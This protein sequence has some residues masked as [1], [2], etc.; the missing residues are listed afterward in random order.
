MRGD[1]R[2]CNVVMTLAKRRQ[3]KQW[4]FERRVLH[5]LSLP[6]LKSEIESNFRSVVPVHF[7]M[8]PF[9]LDPCMDMMIDVYLIGAS[10]SKFRYMGECEKQIFLR[11]EDEI[12]HSKH[13]LFSV[14]QGWTFEYE[15]A[16]HMLYDKIDEITICWWK[17][18]LGEGETLYRLRQS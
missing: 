5:R 12:M 8:H 13:V 9:L 1:R 16:V 2:M 6:Q 7:L 18:G 4:D 15:E 17:R 14:L 10:Y 11:C 3:E